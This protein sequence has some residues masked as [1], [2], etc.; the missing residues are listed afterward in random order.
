MLCN[1][2]L[3]LGGAGSKCISYGRAKYY[4]NLFLTGQNLIEVTRKFNM[5]R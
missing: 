3:N 4:N 1:I 5:L 2:I